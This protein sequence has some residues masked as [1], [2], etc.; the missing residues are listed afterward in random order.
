MK[1]YILIMAM[2]LLVGCEE[3][4][5]EPIVARE[6][7]VAGSWYPDTEFLATNELNNFF[8]EIPPAEIG[9]SIKAMIV[10][11]AGWKFSGLMAASAFKLL[12]GSKYETVIVIGPAH[13]A[14]FFGASIAPVTHYKS[15][16]GM[17]KLSKKAKGLL[18]EPNFVSNAEYHSQEHSI[19]IELPFLQKVLGDFEL[20]PILI[21]SNTNYEQLEQIAAS[22]KTIV[23]DSTLIVVSSDFTHY[24]PNY[25]YIPFTEN[26][27]ENIKELDNGALNAIVGKGPKGFYDYVTDTGITV[28]GRYPIIV[29]LNM[30]GD[31][32]LNVRVSAY[33]TSGRMTGDF[34]NSV[35][36][37]SL[38]FFEEGSGQESLGSEEKEVLMKLARETIELYVREGKTLEPDMGIISDYLG[39][40]KKQGAFV[41]LD[42]NGALRGSIGHL[43]PHEELYL[44]VRDNAISAVS[45]DARFSPVQP[46]ELD[47]IE[48]TVSVLGIPVLVAVNSWEEYLDVLVPLKDGVIIRYGGKQSTYLP[49]VWGQLPDKE[50]FLS[51]LCMKQGS[52]ADC[53]KQPG[54]EIYKYSAQVFYEHEFD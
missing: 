12:E 19:E 29:L 43:L 32:A 13:T 46:D 31:T 15:P 1:K 7:A 38:I 25:G 14:G 45:K 40:Q 41:S 22:I 44:T 35:S 23:D 16:L 39:L 51:R 52:S 33:D 20:V 36:Y 17:V 47:E 3:I 24:G 18:S 53:W 48:I 11:H 37:V 5:E 4:T 21:G 30:L 49:Q 34:T 8:N 10:P 27:E 9:G 2:V 26:V 28:C 50:E 54:A 6:T 42:K